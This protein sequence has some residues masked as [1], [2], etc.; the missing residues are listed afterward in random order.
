VG[1]FSAPTR[2][3]FQR[4]FPC[5]LRSAAEP[6]GRTVKCSDTISLQPHP[7]VDFSQSSSLSLC[8]LRRAF[9]YIVDQIGENCTLRVLLR[10]FS[11][12]R[13]HE[14]LSLTSLGVEMAADSLE[15][16]EV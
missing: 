6:Y 12:S 1:T 11:F 15:I 8:G 16:A 5:R 3:H 9:V 7:L 2:G 10:F 4:R 13:R 14:E